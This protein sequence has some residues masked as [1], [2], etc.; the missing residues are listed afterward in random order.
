MIHHE[1][2]EGNED[3]FFCF[4]HFVFFV[5]QTANAD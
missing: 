1:E 3:L 4:V 5:V 2:R